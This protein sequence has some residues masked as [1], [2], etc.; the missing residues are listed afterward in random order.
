MS[1]AK[2]GFAGSKNKFELLNGH[3]EEEAKVV[4]EGR[5]LRVAY[6]GVAILLQEMKTKKKDMLEK[7]GD[8]SVTG[9]SS[10]IAS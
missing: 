2:H 10:I 3:D 5:K 9:V 7:V 4:P 8:P 1:D 6:Q